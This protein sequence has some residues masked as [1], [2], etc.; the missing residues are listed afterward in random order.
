[1]PT[2]IPSQQ[3]PDLDRHN[4]GNTHWSNDTFAGRNNHA[5]SGD[6]SQ[7]STAQD[8]QSR[9]NSGS[10]SS[11]HNNTSST[12]ATGSDYAN[13]VRGQEGAPGGGWNTNVSPVNTAA[14]SKSTSLFGKVRGTITGARN[15]PLITLAIMMFGGGSFLAMTPANFASLSLSHWLQN[16]VIKWDSQSTSFEKRAHKI[17]YQRIEGKWWYMLHTSCLPTLW[18]FVKVYD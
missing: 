14:S 3:K 12:G 7:S 5:G 1:M 9:E 8:L 18:S 10:S 13:S 2:P 6:H 11:A 4:P 17:M 15:K 16:S